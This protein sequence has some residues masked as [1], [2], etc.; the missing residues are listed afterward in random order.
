MGIYRE[1][2]L[3]IIIGDKLYT[4]LVCLLISSVVI[5]QSIE[6]L[7]EKNGFKDFTLGDSFHKWQN[8]LSIKEI[9]GDTKRCFYTANCC[10]TLYNYPLKTIMLDF[11]NNKLVRIL[12]LHEAIPKKRWGFRS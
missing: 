8:S 7:D 11:E 1:Q 9:N 5:S 6:K 2:I 3:E 12:L 4:V 10:N